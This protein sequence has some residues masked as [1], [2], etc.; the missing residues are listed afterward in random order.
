MYFTYF[1]M[2]IKNKKIF[3]ST[4]YVLVNRNTNFKL[5]LKRQINKIHLLKYA[6]S[7]GIHSP[8][9]FSSDVTLAQGEKQ[10]SSKSL[11]VA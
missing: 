11:K 4:V 8:N 3:V 6:H 2:L 9:T 7:F 5:R 1:F 10:S